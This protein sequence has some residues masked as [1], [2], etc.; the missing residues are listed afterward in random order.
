MNRF[1]DN[2]PDKVYHGTISTYKDSLYSGIDINRCNDFVDFGRGFYTTTNYE[3]AKS[4]CIRNTKKNNL[5]RE[6]KISQNYF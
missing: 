3:Q 4:F 5:L 6:K 2:L 1:I